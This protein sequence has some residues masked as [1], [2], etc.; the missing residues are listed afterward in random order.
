M[1]FL[2]KKWLGLQDFD[3]SYFWGLFRQHPEKQDIPEVS[4]IRIFENSPKSAY[5]EHNIVQ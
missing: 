3:W 2:L 1:Q 5:I 4:E